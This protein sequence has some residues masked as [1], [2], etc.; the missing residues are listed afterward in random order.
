MTLAP[1]PEDP[2][3]RRQEHRKCAEVVFANNISGILSQYLGKAISDIQR[4]GAR[5]IAEV[6]MDVLYR[7]PAA[8]LT[9]SRLTGSPQEWDAYLSTVM[10][11]DTKLAFY[12][13][14]GGKAVAEAVKDALR[15][16]GET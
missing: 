15:N 1:I 2:E 12:Q 11:E 5:L 9:P 3:E 8:M 14:I 16:L 4:D 13:W 6:G 7:T 10:A